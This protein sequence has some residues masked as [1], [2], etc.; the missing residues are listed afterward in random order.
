MTSQ[1]NQLKMQNT[2]WGYRSPRPFSTKN[3]VDIINIAII[4]Q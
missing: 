2:G 1:K 4:L 3:K